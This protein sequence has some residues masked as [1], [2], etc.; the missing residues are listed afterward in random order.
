MRT[1]PRTPSH[2]PVV[3][4]AV[5]A[6][7][8]LAAHA[9]GQ[10]AG[11]PAPSR[12][13]RPPAIT[14][15]NATGD[16]AAILALEQKMEA[17]VVKGD[18][19]FVDSLLSTDFHFRH[20]DGWVRGDKAGGMEDDRK[21]F[22]NR[23]VD[24]EYL[25]HDL[26]GSTIEMLGDLAI[27]HGRYVSLYMPKNRNN[28]NPAQ[29]STIWFERVWAK[30][31]GQWKWLSHRTVH[32][33]TPSPAGVDPSAITPSQVAGYVPGLPVIK[34]P[35]V[36]YPPESPEAAEVLQFEKKVGDA[37]VSGDAAFFDS[38]TTNDFSMI[39]GDIWTKGG[40]PALI[41]TKETFLKKVQN[42][43]YLAH[44]F[45]SVRVEMHGDVAITFGRYVA[46][47]KGSNPERAW[48]SVWFERIYKKRNGRWNYVSH[49]TVHGASYG[50]TRESVSDK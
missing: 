5:L 6:C 50:P 39:H 47:I 25:V 17:A 21:A 45:D 10:Q 36:T 29:L 35:A 1:L 31:D 46:T 11:S 2:S 3:F 15:A 32:G 34:V 24:K 23:V 37:I 4:G 30:R 7:L 42:K 28:A 16:A 13:S 20:G 9:S 22:L 40:P 26:G 44:D 41:D 8:A 43:S 12:P 19:A 33:P 49:R 18:V 27:T 48:F 38:V 14:V